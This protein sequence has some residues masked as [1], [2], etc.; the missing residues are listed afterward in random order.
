MLQPGCTTTTISIGSTIA[1]TWSLE[2]GIIFGPNK[3]FC[4]LAPSSPLPGLLGT[5]IIRDRTQT[6]TSSPKASTLQQPRHSSS[7]K[8]IASTHTIAL[9][10][11]ITSSMLLKIHMGH[12]SQEYNTTSSLATSATYSPTLSSPP[13]T[14]RISW[15]ASSSVSTWLPLEQ[16][17]SPSSVNDQARIQREDALCGKGGYVTRLI[18]TPTLGQIGQEG[19]ETQPWPPPGPLH[20]CWYLLV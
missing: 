8:T 6:S 15:G 13:S 7:R 19:P 2:Q 4:F 11:P 9:E 10:G 18:W 1:P 14:Q 12:R 17:S 20:A 3:Y 5:L 16:I